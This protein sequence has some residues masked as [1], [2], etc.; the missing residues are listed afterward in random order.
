MKLDEGLS[1]EK[2]S[3]DITPLIDI[4]F[5]LVLFFAV[6]TSF[7]SGEDLEALKAN[8]TSITGDKE[9]LDADLDAANQRI[10]DLDFNIISLRQLSD[11]QALQ[12][13]ALQ[14]R[15]TDQSS[16]NRQLQGRI[17]QADSELDEAKSR[18]D[19]IYTK[20]I[21]ERTLRGEQEKLLFRLED[22]L[23][24]KNRESLDLEIV[25]AAANRTSE[26]LDADLASARSEA[27][28]LKTE[29]DKFKK[30][31]QLD[32]DQVE[33][34]LRAQ[35]NLQSDLDSYLKNNQLGI[36]REKQRIIL[37]LSDKILFDSGSPELKAEGAE[38]LREV[39]TAIKT[40][41]G[42][43]QIQIGGHTDNIPVSGKNSLWPSNWALSAA[44]AVNVVLLLE[45]DVG[46]DPD[47]LSA[48]GYGEHHPIAD[49]GTAE[50]RARNRR[51]EMVLVPR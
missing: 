4:V 20:F 44:R 13:Q 8:L 12:L 17:E 19:Q 47:L 3:L 36:K 38:L 15:I 34:L 48:V 18:F 11:S 31:A 51:I 6:S 25:L 22:L 43:L 41:L 37:Q 50:G 32:R 39:G 21:D 24:E 27:Q 23:A 40:R 26:E 7:I 49:N 10:R 33:R 14:G 45:D 9:A 29:L 1:Y 16:R 46:I 5:L 28:D 35:Q 30:I 2:L 42:D